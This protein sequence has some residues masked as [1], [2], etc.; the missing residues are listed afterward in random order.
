MP[1]R[2]QNQ[3]L[4]PAFGAFFSLFRLD[5]HWAR[6]CL[7]VSWISHAEFASFHPRCGGWHW[8]W[9]VSVVHLTPIAVLSAELERWINSQRSRPLGR[10]PTAQQCHWWTSQQWNPSLT[11]SSFSTSSCSRLKAQLAVWVGVRINRDCVG[12][13]CSVMWGAF[14]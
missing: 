14:R 12:T 5:I 9:R 7:A 1:F 13:L 11:R 6:R 8:Q 10:E 2:K 3:G 4:W